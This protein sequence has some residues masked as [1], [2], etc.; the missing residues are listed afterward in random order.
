LTFFFKC[1][2]GVLYRVASC[3]KGL[4]DF[5]N[6]PHILNI[7]RNRSDSFTTIGTYKASERAQLRVRN[8]SV[9]TII[10]IVITTFRKQ[11]WE[12]LL[13]FSHNAYIR[14][15][16]EINTRTNFNWLNSFQRFAKNNIFIYNDDQ[17]G[18][19]RSEI[20]ESVYTII[21]SIIIAKH[22]DMGT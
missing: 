1:M 9:T 15:K 7:H 19:V 12:G 8:E 4:K 20:T 17:N 2:A 6:Y 21:S 14:T 16:L 10:I 11:F 13:R 5:P 3:K 22:F 18:S